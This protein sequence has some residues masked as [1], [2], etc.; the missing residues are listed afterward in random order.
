[1]KGNEPTNNNPT[2]SL[3]GVEQN[4]DNS[5][6]HFA[7]GYLAIYVPKQIAYDTE[8]V[9]RNPKYEGMLFGQ[10]YYLIKSELVEKYNMDV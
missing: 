3:E 9:F 7:P 4:D 8:L 10:Y 5:V 2:P 1:M 6:S